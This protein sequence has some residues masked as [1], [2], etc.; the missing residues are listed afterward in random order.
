MLSVNRYPS[1]HALMSLDMMKSAVHTKSCAVR[2]TPS[3][4]V[5]PLRR[6]K[7]QVSPSEEI[8]PFSTLG[9]SVASSGSVA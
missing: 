6:W 7:V 8:P 9:T 2:G 3:L 1:L 4:H 5:S